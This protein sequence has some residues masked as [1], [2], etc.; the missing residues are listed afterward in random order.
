M[1]NNNRKRY[2]FQDEEKL[3]ILNN[4]KN[5]EIK[6]IANSLNLKKQQVYDFLKNRKLLKFKQDLKTLKLK[7][8]SL[9]KREVE[10]LK[11]FALPIQKMEEKLFISRTTIVTHKNNIFQKLNTHSRAE[12]V[13]LAIKNNIL[14]IDDFILESE[15]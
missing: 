11:H 8:Y 12:S 13:I 1:S 3:F 14:T 2:K 15:Q 10:V 5:I 7:N 4:Y 6:E 9:T